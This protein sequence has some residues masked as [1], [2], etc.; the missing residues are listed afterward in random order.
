MRILF[1]FLTAYDPPGT[2][3][4]SLDP[5]GVYQIAERLAEQL[6]PAVRERMQRVRFLTTMAVGA[7]VTEDLEEN[8][9]NRD[10][11]PFLVWEWLV[12]EALIRA[13][14]DSGTLS[15]VPGTDVTRRARVNHG[16]LDARSYLKTPRVFGFNGV[17]KRL[18]VRLGLV[19]V[20]LAP[21]PQAE[22]LVDAWARSRGLGGFAGARSIIEKWR[23][24]VRRSLEESPPRT[25]PGWSTETWRELAA[26]F[27]PGKCVH[28]EKRQLKHL[29]LQGSGD[30]SLGALP[31]LWD[32]WADLEG[33]T[34]G[35]EPLH[36]ELGRRLPQYR[37]LLDG[38]RTYEAFSRS[39]TDAFDLL[40]AEAAAPDARGF[41]VTAI[42]TDEDFR[43][44]VR[45]LENRYAAA[46]AALSE[47]I[48]PIGSLQHL[49]A[50]KFSDLGEP[51]DPGRCA[52]ALCAHHEQVQKKKSAG[53]KRPWFDRLSTDRIY[54]RHPYRKPRKEILPK[55][56][57]SSYRG[58][59][60]RRFRDDLS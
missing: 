28:Q 41:I 6:V 5:L 29:L 27:A 17:Y 33:K 53:G 43:T 42:A 32:I 2:A 20:H 23:A 10:A 49:F 12:V 35:E 56:Y 3:E 26:A 9:D 50:E 60:I 31:P 45:N 13:I 22:S 8:S 14:G 19:D 34:D 36:K 21:G 25:N 58:A 18:A 54:V 16:Y 47:V 39:I 46:Q 59:P 30:Q 1:P 37:Q 57:V 24:A 40:L 38:I 55:R 4:G 52:E 51:M 48:T 7:Y 11:S 44:S 15:G